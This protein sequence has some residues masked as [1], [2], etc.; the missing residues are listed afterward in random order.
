MRLAEIV[1]GVVVNVIEADPAALPDWAVDWPEA[2]EAGPGWVVENGNLVPPAAAESPVPAVVS[3]FQA[4]AALFQAG[5]LPAVEAAV[6]SA[7]PLTQMAWADAVEFRRDSAA[8]ASIAA[9]LG[10]DTSAV[11]TLFRAAADISA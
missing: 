8:I 10:L 6:A 2:G 9:A 11:D 7:D 4:R 5:I 1:N 3:R